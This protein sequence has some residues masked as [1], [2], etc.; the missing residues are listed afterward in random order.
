MA[1]AFG[2][3]DRWDEA[4]QNIGRT[5][6]LVSALGGTALIARALRRPSLPNL[7]LAFGGAALVRR[8]VIGH[9]RIYGM[10]GID[11]SGR[12]AEREERL[13]ETHGAGR[14]RERAPLDEVEAASDDSFPASDPPAWILTAAGHPRS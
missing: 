9:S 2:R 8:G 5:E 4:R 7:L 1:K 13:E 11:R 12:S 14:R 10:L 6:R 3:D